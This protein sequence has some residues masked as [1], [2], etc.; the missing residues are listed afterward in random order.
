MIASFKS[1]EVSSS[2][3][4]RRMR[5]LSSSLDGSM[6]G[7]G[8]LLLH[9][10]LAFSATLLGVAPLP[11]GEFPPPIAGTVILCASSFSGAD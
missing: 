5:E 7:G 2:L 8:P 6:R 9:A 11:L 3:F 4:L 10:S 1:V